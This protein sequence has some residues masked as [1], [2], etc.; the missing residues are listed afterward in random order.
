MNEPRD[1]H[2]QGGAEMQAWI[3]EMS[4]YMKQ[5]APRQ[6]VTIGEEGF[7]AAST[8]HTDQCVP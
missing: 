6:L 3:E 8:C 1:E 5:M 7:Y 4:R 2:A